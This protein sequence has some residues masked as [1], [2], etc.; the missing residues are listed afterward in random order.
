MRSPGSRFLRALGALVCLGVA[1]PAVAGAQQDS[2]LPASGGAT[3]AD[4][5]ADR[6]VGGAGIDVVQVDGLIDPANAALVRRVVRD[7]ERTGSTLLVVQLDASGAV[8][9]DIEDLIEIVESSKVPIGVWVGPSNGGA[10]GAAALF[11][12]AAPVVDV[13]SGADLGP[14]HPVRYDEPGAASREDVAARIAELAAARGRDP[15]ADA[16]ERVVERRLGS[17][18]AEELGLV[19]GRA[20]T[21]GDFIVRLDETIVET[22]AGPVTLDTADVIGEGLDRRRRPNQEVRFHQLD[23]V[24]QAA[25][26]LVTP[27][28]AYLLFVAGLALIVFELYTA[29]VGIAGAV[30]AVA[31]VGASYGFSHLPVAPWAVGLL[32][33]G[34][35]GLT[36]DLQ[37]GGLGAWTYIGSAALVAG[38]V[39]LY[40]GSSRLD[41][42]WWVLVL[43]IGST[44][45]F[46]L[47]GMTAMVRSRF[48]TPTIGREDLVGEL[49]VAEVDVAPD[50]V[51]R[52]R[53]A[54]WR[55]RTNRAT[56]VKAGD[57]VR[58]VAIEG[59]VLEVEPEEGGA[60]D[61]RDRARRRS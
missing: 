21:V 1:V 26:T 16:I 2:A 47:S 32:L 30:G 8:D 28:V 35:F 48:S 58:V 19:D 5:P 41:P 39:W 54:L 40:D 18:D 23:L 3:G 45:V 57:R 59:V 55:A 53:D 56:P 50:G 31:V 37:A 22:A 20:P 9:T 17:G 14:V 12:L 61:Y 49:G 6:V 46:M 51:V 43:V 4:A 29:G 24:Q 42:S 27:W 15:S 38:S 36:V 33:V 13:A 10:R 34:M 11:A 60:R 44:I 7:V 52:L 25:H